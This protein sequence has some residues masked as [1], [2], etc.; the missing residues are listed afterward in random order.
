VSCRRSGKV[1]DMNYFAFHLGFSF[2]AILACFSQDF[3]RFQWV[4]RQLYLPTQKKYLKIAKQ[5][6]DLSLQV[7]KN[8]LIWIIKDNNIMFH[9]FISKKI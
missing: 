1:K 6:L 4:A 7:K 9:L 5:K 2:V 8:Y 3:T